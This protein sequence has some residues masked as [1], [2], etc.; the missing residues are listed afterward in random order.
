MSRREKWDTVGEGDEGL[1]ASQYARRHL[2][3]SQRVPHSR[4]GA[5]L[6]NFPAIISQFLGGEFISSD[7]QALLAIAHR[8]HEQERQSMITSVGNR[9]KRVEP[10]VIQARKNSALISH[11]FNGNRCN[12]KVQPHLFNASVL[13]MAQQRMLLA[14]NEHARDR[15]RPFPFRRCLARGRI[16]TPCGRPR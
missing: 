14:R 11:H 15:S 16:R 8:R 6:N 4:A 5:A 3:I 1:I 7:S 2:P 12:R 9:C 10:D 13:S